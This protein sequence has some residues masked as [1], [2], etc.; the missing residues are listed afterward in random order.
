MKKISLLLL[1]LPMMAF[2]GCQKQLP[3]TSDQRTFDIYGPVRE[4][5]TYTMTINAKDA[6]VNWK[7]FVKESKNTPAIIDV[8]DKADT[9]RFFD[10]D[11]LKMEDRMLYVRDTLNGNRLTRINHGRYYNYLTELY[12]TIDFTYNMAGYP[13]NVIISYWDH[14]SNLTYQYDKKN[15]LAKAEGELSRESVVQ[16]VSKEYTYISK[17]KYGNWTRRVAKVQ[18][19]ENDIADEDAVEKHYVQYQIED[20]QFTYRE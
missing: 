5:R 19:I 2:A 4:C 1:L 9:L 17:D 8:A 20:R 7:Q 16:K 14:D 13:E 11:S 18:V 3:Q 6:G 15:R 12:Y 10:N